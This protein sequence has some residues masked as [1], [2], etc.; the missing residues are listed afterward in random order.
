MSEENGLNAFGDLFNEITT[1]E[2]NPSGRYV[3]T[4]PLQS[5]VSEEASEI[6]T[7]Y[8]DTVE[9]PMSSFDQEVLMSSLVKKSDKTSGF[10]EFDYEYAVYT[11]NETYMDPVNQASFNRKI[12][13]MPVDVLV[14]LAGQHLLYAK[15][16]AENP[17]APDAL[18]GELC[19]TLYRAAMKKIDESGLREDNQI[20]IKDY[21]A[22]MARG[23]SDPKVEQEIVATLRKNANDLKELDDA[24]SQIS[25][26]A[27]VFKYDRVNK[28]EKYESDLIADL[29]AAKEPRLLNEVDNALTVIADSIRGDGFRA[30]RGDAI[31]EGLEKISGDIAAAKKAG[32]RKTG[33]QYEDAT[34]EDELENEKKIEDI[35]TRLKGIH[36]MIGAVRESIT[37]KKSQPKFSLNV[38]STWDSIKTGFTERVPFFGHREV[39]L[40]EF[41]LAALSGNQD[42]GAAVFNTFKKIAGGKIGV[43]RIYA[44]LDAQPRI[45]VP[46]GDISA[47]VNGIALLSHLQ[48]YRGSNEFSRAC[49]MED[50]KKKI[51]KMDKVIADLEKSIQVAVQQM[52]DSRISEKSAMIQVMDQIMGRTKQESLSE[53][54]NLKNTLALRGDVVSEVERENFIS[55]FRNKSLG[56]VGC[57]TRLLQDLYLSTRDKFENRVLLEG[58][59]TTSGMDLSKK[60]NSRSRRNFVSD[61]LENYNKGVPAE[62]K[63]LVADAKAGGM[64]KEELKKFKKA[65]LAALMGEHTA[66][67]P[68]ADRK[69]CCIDRK[70]A[71]GTVISDFYAG[72]NEKF[73]KDDP[74]FYMKWAATWVQDNRNKTSPAARD[75]YRP[76]LT[77]GDAMPDEFVYAVQAYCQFNGYRAPRIRRGQDNHGR[78]MEVF[79]ERSEKV[80]S[81]K[82]YISAN[83]NKMEKYLKTMLG[84][85]DK[86]R[87]RITGIVDSLRAVAEI[88]HAIHEAQKEFNRPD[89]SVAARNTF[90]NFENMN[91]AAVENEIQNENIDDKKPKYDDEQSFMMEEKEDYEEEYELWN[92]VYEDKPADLEPEENPLNVS[93]KKSIPQAPNAPEP[94]LSVLVK[95]Q[96][97]DLSL[98]APPAPK[99][100]TAPSVVGD[101]HKEEKVVRAVNSDLKSEIHN[102]KKKTSNSTLGILSSIEEKKED[103]PVQIKKEK[104]EDMFA[105][106]KKMKK[107]ERTA[108]Y[109]EAQ[110]KA[111]SAAQPKKNHRTAG[112]GRSSQ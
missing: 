95:P 27:K 79:V 11:L 28:E 103:T 102:F 46:E 92:E 82:E 24:E 61:K 65:T 75:S 25:D 16:S 30:G 68:F 62:V 36:S 37:G 100:P 60:P 110:I 14:A 105:Q 15:Y 32:I 43:T 51:K 39:R 88:D 35:Q 64:S 3:E 91:A 76:V 58:D 8:E 99:P 12:N 17:G 67:V 10:I 96:P 45:A 104:K 26:L 90:V 55:N 1:L 84:T 49:R 56:M 5:V 72:K 108:E 29:L 18:S 93:R 38:E 40:T 53:V 21:F 101:D 23:E 22:A 59:G 34:E 109:I 83:Q 48:T 44:D 80:Q 71:D 50:R 97:Q 2:K 69:I 13:E 94:E 42:P 87:T 6:F 98:K 41:P 106:I 111:S 9:Y 19:L 78:D 7:Q 74:D 73:P 89:E 63:R 107:P 112:F 33:A 31:I 4:H 57:H 47:L 70:E 52:D 54:E 66:F 81:Y 85:P 77:R 20:K 86:I